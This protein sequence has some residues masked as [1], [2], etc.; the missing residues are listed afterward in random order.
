MQTNISTF[1]QFVG[2]KVELS[3]KDSRITYQYH[4]FNYDVDFENDLVI[5]DDSDSDC[6]TYIPLNKITEIINL[7]DDLYST[8]VNVKYGDEQIN[9]CCAESRPALVK[10]DRCLHI[11]KDDEQIWII[12][13]QGQYGSQF[14]S[15]RI[16]KKLCDDCIETLVNGSLQDKGGELYE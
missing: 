16:S 10:C 4:N 11:F 15:E 14:D 12:N 2:H 1:N 3:T 5:M 6:K 13:Q 7:T 8:V 9:I